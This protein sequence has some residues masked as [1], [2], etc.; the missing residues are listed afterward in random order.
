MSGELIYFC[1]FFSYIFINGFPLGI[2]N[3]KNVENQLNHGKP[4]VMDV[5]ECVQHEID[6][7]FFLFSDFFLL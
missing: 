3:K 1:Y 5:I 7:F 6:K 4:E 2:K